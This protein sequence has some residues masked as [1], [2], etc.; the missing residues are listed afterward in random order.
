MKMIHLLKYIFRN[1]IGELHSVLE[2]TYSLRVFLFNLIG[3]IR[4]P[5][6]NVSDEHV[7]KI[8]TAS[9]VIIIISVTLATGFREWRWCR[10]RLRSSPLR[11]V[12]IIGCT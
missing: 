7:K 5:I 1:K 8:L 4:T 3:S 10:S 6:P 11:H 2:Y 9:L 12:V